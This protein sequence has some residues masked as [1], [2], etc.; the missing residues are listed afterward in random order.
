[1]KRTFEVFVM[2]VTL[3]ARC[4]ARLDRGTPTGIVMDS[5]GAVVPSVQLT[6]TNADAGVIYKIYA[7]VAR[8]YAVP[9]C[10]LILA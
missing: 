7:T 3:A 2:L 9:T 6:I 10:R 1:M 5:T 8:A 4:L